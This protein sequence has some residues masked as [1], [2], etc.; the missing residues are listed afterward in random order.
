MLTF[1]ISRISLQRYIWRQGLSHPPPFHV[2][3]AGSC[4]CHRCDPFLPTRIRQLLRYAI[5]TMSAFWIVWK[6]FKHRTDPFKLDPQPLSISQ[7]RR[8]IAWS[9][10]SLAIFSCVAVHIVWLR[11]AGF[12]K[13]Y[14]DIHEFGVPYFVSSVFVMLM[15]RS[16]KF[17]I[18]PLTRPQVHDLYFYIIHRAMHSRLLSIKIVS[19]ADGTSLVLYN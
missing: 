19:A 12:T 11:K 7:I 4:T 6:V 17:I 8:E 16:C 5:I 18:S 1:P 15:V 3:R 10:C 13:I 2:R 14:G 9:L